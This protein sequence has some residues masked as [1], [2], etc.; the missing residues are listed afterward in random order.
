M[1]LG[2]YLHIP[3]CASRCRYC[4]FVTWAGKDHLIPAYL[5][6]LVREIE[7][8]RG[9]GLVAKT[10]FFG[11][12]TPSLLKAEEIGG[13]LQAIEGSFRVLP[14]AEITLEANPADGGLDYFKALVGLGVDRLSLGAQSF[15]DGELRL[16]GR[17]HRA[18]DIARTFAQAR[19]AGLENVNLDLIYG[20]PGQ[21]LGAFRHSLESALGLGPEHL[22]LYALSLEEATPLEK[23]VSRGELPAPDPDQQADMYL[24]AERLLD[25]A[26]YRHYELSNWALPG[27][28]CRHNL[29][30]WEGGP[31]L[32]LGAGAHSYL[33]GVRSARVSSVEDYLQKLEAAESP[34]AESEEIGPEMERAE[35]MFLGLRLIGGIEGGAFAR[36]FGGPPRSFFGPQIE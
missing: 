14:G 35:A 6:A 19:G 24:L 18:G 13:F 30:Y 28:E 1:T 8:F 7:G 10:I 17:R 2:L 9:K 20:L 3:F 34:I 25:G 23:A 36:R 12:G 21:G 31:Y 22:S 32:G 26:G 33:M 29:I 15:D 11:G 5:K 16:L 27:R 4:D